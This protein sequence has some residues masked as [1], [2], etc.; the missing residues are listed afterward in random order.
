MWDI[1]IIA[2]LLEL[3]WVPTELVATPTLDS[4][5]HWVPAGGAERL[6]RQAHGIDRDAIFR[7]FFRKL[8]DSQL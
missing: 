3:S 8:Q 2:W 4:G 1:I 6:M 7:D 5:L